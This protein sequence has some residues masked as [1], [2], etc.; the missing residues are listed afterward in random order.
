MR[1]LLTGITLAALSSSALSDVRI[2]HQQGHYPYDPSDLSNQIISYEGASV[3]TFP[4]L[5]NGYQ[6]MEGHATNTVKQVSP[7]LRALI[8]P[9]GEVTFHSGARL[10]TI[11]SEDA[12]GK[13][14]N[15]AAG[16]HTWKSYN[17]IVQFKDNWTGPVKMSVYC[18]ADDGARLDDSYLWSD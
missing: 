3:A 18:S 12:P 15:L 6:P 11:T 17:W 9:S 16:S 7:E 4:T 1:A 13:P 10:R 2:S 14:C 5:P 8:F